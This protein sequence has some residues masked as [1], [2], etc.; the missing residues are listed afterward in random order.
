MQFIDIILIIYL[1]NFAEHM[2]YLVKKRLFMMM[3][4]KVS[5]DWVYFLPLVVNA[6]NKKPIKALGYLSPSEINS[7]WDDNKVRAAQRAEKIKP[8][9]EPDWKTQNENQ[10]N[11]LKNQRQHLQPG[12]FV[13]VDKK[14]GVFNKSFFAQVSSFLLLENEKRKVPTNFR[15]SS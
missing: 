6:L 2:V 15:F 1:A 12:A 7:E 3:R 10:E 8:Y 9:H 11:Y 4:S 5:D 14:V 13:F